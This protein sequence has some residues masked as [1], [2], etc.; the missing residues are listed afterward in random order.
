MF[1][2]AIYFTYGS[3]HAQLLNHVILFTTPCIVVCKTPLS[4]GFLRQE[5]QSALP[6]PPP[7]DL[8]NP[9]IKPVSPM[10]PALQAILYRWA[11]REAHG[12][13][14]MPILISRSSHPRSLLLCPQ[15]HSQRLHLYSCPADRS[16]CTIFCSPWGCKESDMAWWLNNNIADSLPVQ[17]NLTY[18]VKQ[19]NSNFFFFKLYDVTLVPV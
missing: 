8:P 13:V 15:V 11:V 1:P 14:Y 6:F 12:G 5:Y 7:G 9:G 10:S 19:L 18:I 4:M 2:P 16:I 17:Q 3:V